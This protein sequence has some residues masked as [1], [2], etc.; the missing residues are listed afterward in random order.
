M[1]TQQIHGMPGTS[2][3]TPTAAPGGQAAGVGTHD[4]GYLRM[5]FWIGVLGISVPLLLLLNEAWLDGTWASRGSLSAYYHSGARDIFV[6]GLC[7]VGIFLVFYRIE[8]ARRINFWT[9]VA[10]AA[11]LGVALV[12]TKAPSGAPQT[13]FQLEVGQLTLQYW[14]FGFAITFIVLLVP[15]SWS[16][17]RGASTQAWRTYHHT[18]AVLIVGFCLYIAFSKVTGIGEQQAL[19][20][21]ETGAVWSFSA[22]WLSHGLALRSRLVPQK[23]RHL[24]PASSP[25][26]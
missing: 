10:G 19:L 7:C 15:I 22:S 21:G 1:S 8:G 25:A 11:C 17:A 14:H 26:A 4:T 24:L 3:A 20:V 12:P 9:S 2:S 23:L 5:Q 13:P 18:C 6:G 16:Y